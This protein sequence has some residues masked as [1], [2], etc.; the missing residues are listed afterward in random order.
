MLIPGGDSGCACK[1]PTALKPLAARMGLG[2]IVMWGG[3]GLKG[4]GSPRLKVRWAV[5]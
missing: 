3:G 5:S 4:A 2:P 1:Q